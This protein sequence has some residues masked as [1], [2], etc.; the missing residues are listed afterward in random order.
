MVIEALKAARDFI[1]SDRQDL[2]E[3]LTVKGEIV[4]EDDIDRGAMAEYVNVLAV[5]DEALE[6][7][8]AAP[9]AAP[10]VVDC[11]A[12]GVCVQ[13]G[14]RAEMPA[15]VPPTNEQIDAAVK[16][17]FENPIVAGQRPFKK[18]MLAAFEAAQRIAVKGRP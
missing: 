18:R 14:L 9:P 7:A 5:I 16:A 17:W 10:K 2:A 1:E 8:L 15:P 4:F 11:R 12:T 6:Q 3:S 13:S